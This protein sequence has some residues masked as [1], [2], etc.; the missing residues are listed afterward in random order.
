MIYKISKFIIIKLLNIIFDEKYKI[1]IVK[2]I[3]KS[4]LPSY[5]KKRHNDLDTINNSIYFDRSWYSNYYFDISNCG[6]DPAI[7]YL[8]NGINGKINPS[9]YFYSN[10]YYLIHPDVEIADINPLLHYEKY[11]KYE[12][13]KICLADIKEM[14]FHIGT[15]ECTKFFFKRNKFNTNFISVVASFSCDGKI[16]D[17]IIYL[18]NHIYQI[19]DFT[20]L[21][22][23]SPI[24]INELNK[25]NN[26][27][28]VCICFRHG[29]Y[30]FGSYKIGYKY[31]VRNKIF[32]D[33]D[34]LIFINDSCYGPIYPFKNII[35]DFQ[36]KKCD[37]YGL[38]SSTDPKPYIP[39][40]FYIFK[41]NV[42]MS[43]IFIKFINS[44]KKEL[45]PAHVIHNYEMVFTEILYNAGYSYST[46]VNTKS[47]LKNLNI[48]SIIPTKYPFTLIRNY[49]YPLVKV[50]VIK[51]STKES[52]PDTL[53]YIK[54]V[55]SDI[56][57]IIKKDIN[58]YNKGTKHTIDKV[59][60]YNIFEEYRK[61]I[62]NIKRSIALGN[63]I[64]T[65]FLVNMTSMFPAEEL[66]CRLMTEE[67]FDVSL[68]VIPDV[69]FGNNEMIKILKSTFKELNKKY[70]FTK[71]AVTIEN[72]K[73]TEYHDIIIDADLVCYP[74]PY[75][76]SY[77]LYNPH[78]AFKNKILNFHINYGFFR[79]KYD[80]TT[81]KRDNY[82]NFWKIFIET[83]YNLEDYIKYGQCCGMN[84]VLTGYSKMDSLYK[85]LNNKKYKKRKKIIIA[86]HHS[87]EGGYNNTLSLSN[88][89]NYSDFILT[90]P[91][92]YP[93]IDFIFRPHPAL[94]IFLRSYKK[95]GEKKTNQWID[96]LCSYK[97]IEYSTDGNYFKIFA[98]SD[99]IIQDCGSFLVEY[100][101]T[102][103]PCCYMLK[104]K[105][106]IDE[107]FSYLGKK[108]LNHCYI[109][110]S[111]KDI[112]NFI[113]NVII[114]D[115]DIKKE[116]RD[117][118]SKKEIMINFP[119]ATDTVISHIK[120]ELLSR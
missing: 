29:E 100:F 42:Y 56:Y 104:R 116:K 49:N 10:E 67:K 1:Q 119:H 57:N 63:K 108:C 111:K 32:K 44:I 66:M 11:G 20:I 8:V 86:P 109:A 70:N 113:E 4:F 12:G 51:G 106:D 45:S 75:D 77:S 18:L 74:S 30:D 68:F 60:K 46:Y 65:V 94:F 35:D 64:K 71:L 82:N 7:H 6:I 23:D 28:N 26:I 93:E 73:I 25:I 72:D 54:S 22:I 117:E 39:S 78:H 58:L 43:D 61:T 83:K 3:I 69:R 48:N 17:K 53:E 37:F 47:L 115:N 87:V 120:K 38:S 88:F 112:S 92:N 105:T 101:Y 96:K 33:N 34:N 107:K 19:S 118:F 89:L 76:I 98:E 2:Y 103:K 14:N 55:N 40:F 110:Y 9:P 36:K 91:S 5:F 62:T 50:K 16:S 81:Y 85:Y 15:E 95:W 80:W 114:L 90:L 52:I 41:K 13:R 99:G 27:C 97:N 31:L 21:I 84:A 79:S 24:F 102:G 59:C